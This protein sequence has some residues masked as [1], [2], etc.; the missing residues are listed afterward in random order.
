MKS[1]IESKTLS[2]IISPE[3]WI[4]CINER[5]AIREGK[6]LNVFTDSKHG[7]HMLHTHASI[8]NYRNV[9]CWKFPQKT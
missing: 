3:G 2:P 8:W 4:N 6:K 1:V 5:F 7:F 9:N